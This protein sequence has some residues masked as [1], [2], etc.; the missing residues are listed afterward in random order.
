VQSAFAKCKK[1]SNYWWYYFQTRPTF[2]SIG[3]NPIEQKE[4]TSFQKQSGSIYAKTVID[5]PKWMKSV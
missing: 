1:T 4:P 5:Y 2:L 3:Q